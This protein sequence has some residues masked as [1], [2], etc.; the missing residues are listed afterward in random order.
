MERDDRDDFEVCSRCGA[1]V[2]TE[3]RAFGFG[4]ENVLCGPCAIAR[5]GSYD[6]ERDVW[7]VAPDLTGLA[8]EAYGAAPHEVKKGRR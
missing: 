4:T 8:D 5:G 2:L 6:E 7:T 3:D 1:R